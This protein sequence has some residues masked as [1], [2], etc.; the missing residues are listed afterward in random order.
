MGRG[1]GSVFRRVDF[2]EFDNAPLMT[3]AEKIESNAAVD[4]FFKKALLDDSSFSHISKFLQKTLIRI[5]NYGDF[6]IV[7][8]FITKTTL[9]NARI[10]A[11]GSP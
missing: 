6:M 3:G 1:E 7:P 2:S 10:S 9:F 4:V 5:F 8:S 11:S